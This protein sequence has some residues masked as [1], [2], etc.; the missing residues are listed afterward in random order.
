MQAGH[1][2]PNVREAIEAKRIAAMARKRMAAVRDEAEA[3]IKGNRKAMAK[4]KTSP[5]TQDNCETP[6][7]RAC[8][9]RPNHAS[10]ATSHFTIT[11]VELVNSE[12]SGM[13]TVR[14]TFPAH[15]SH[16]ASNQTLRSNVQGAK[17]LPG[18]IGGPRRLVYPLDMARTVQKILFSGDLGSAVTLKAPSTM[19]QLAMDYSPSESHEAAESRLN[20]TLPTRLR[21]CLHPYQLDGV[22]FGLR[23]GGKFILAD[24]MGLG[25]SLQALSVAFCYKSEWPLLIVAPRSLCSSWHDE[26]LKWLPFAVCGKEPEPPL[27]VCETLSD[28]PGHEGVVIIS[29]EGATRW[30]DELGRYKVIIIDECHSLKSATAQRSKAI[31]PHVKRASRVICLSG[32]P[33][34]SRPAEA[35]TLAHALRPKI[36]GTKRAFEE[37]YCGGRQKFGHWEA[38]GCTNSKELCAIL[39]HTM[40]ICRK[41]ENVVKQMLP[42]KTR[43]E[44]WID[45]PAAAQMWENHQIS[46][47][48]NQHPLSQRG[49]KELTLIYAESGP[50]KAATVA[51]KVDA[52]LQA[53][54]DAKVLL[55]A[56][57]RAVLDELQ[58]ALQSKWSLIRLD[59]GEP[60]ASRHN[61]VRRFQSDTKLRL[62]LLSIKVAAH[63]ITLTAAN[64]VMFAE[65][66]W[67]ASDVL[68]AEDRAHRISQQRPV[69]VVYILARG[70]IDELL[71]S[72]VKNK[73]GVTSTTVSGKRSDLATGAQPKKP[74]LRTANQLLTYFRKV[75]EPSTPQYKASASSDS[76]NRFQS[77][78]AIDARSTSTHAAAAHQDSNA[79]QLQPSTRVPSTPMAHS[80]TSHNSGESRGSYS[81]SNSLLQPTRSLL[82]RPQQQPTPSVRHVQQ[83]PERCQNESP[84]PNA[85]PF[86][87]SWKR[88][89]SAPPLP[90]PA[91]PLPRLVDFTDPNPHSRE[92]CRAS[93]EASCRQAP[94]AV[95]DLLNL[96]D[97]ED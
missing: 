57:H 34:I 63:G 50:L 24:E 90:P 2:P 51:D 8:G 79:L 1:F 35:Y 78:Q 40:M 83:T 86:L 36:I 87:T 4:Q 20:R 88:P 12:E 32:T 54:G 48:K 14:V 94:H 11:D 38:K 56:H 70:S 10:T 62:A 58:D 6:S 55:F 18:V 82:K 49:N 75:Q 19:A 67:N 89:R 41:K 77:G 52:V 61:L 26:V 96:S 59:G 37:R 31:L 71:W 7:H 97:E 72:V 42:P 80:S 28:P 5:T 65:L 74:S 84:F 16:V 33:I 15:L 23:Q 53:P 91:P 93:A 45:V 43:E 9:N 64:T 81:Q 27:Q 60:P 92:D 22:R 30:T 3:T 39:H 44:C 47:V 13:P 21:E 69:R 66:P 73:A 85:S 29:F 25:K 68:Q 95:V 17:L 46:R 76:T